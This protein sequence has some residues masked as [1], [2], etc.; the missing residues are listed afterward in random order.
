[1]FTICQ[2]LSRV[3]NLEYH[4]LSSNK[5]FTCR[6]E[7]VCMCNW[8]IINFIQN[9]FF[10]HSWSK[11]LLS[12]TDISGNILATGDTALNKI[13]NPFAYNESLC[14]NGRL[15]IFLFW[16]EAWA[17]AKHSLMLISLSV[18][19]WENTSKPLREFVL[20]FPHQTVTLPTC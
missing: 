18:G 16:D 12:S 19:K 20:F 13:D 8:L 1:M 10:I 5:L 6:I 2:K 4:L 3:W 14:S 7:H 17:S 9:L 15:S 11:Y